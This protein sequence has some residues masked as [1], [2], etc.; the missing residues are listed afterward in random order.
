MS[1]LTVDGEETFQG[2]GDTHVT[3]GSKIFGREI[4]YVNGNP[5]LNTMNSQVMLGMVVA[6]V[7]AAYVVYKKV[8]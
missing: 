7:I 5:Y 3:T 8:K 2:L 1:G 4:P 6:G